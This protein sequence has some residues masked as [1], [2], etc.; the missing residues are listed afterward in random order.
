MRKRATTLVIVLAL[1]L[2]GS[3]AV[4]RGW[5][6]VRLEPTKTWVGV[7]RVHLE[8]SELTVVDNALVGTY[9]IRVPLAPAR[10]DRGTIRFEL[11]G[12]LEQTLV[13]GAVLSGLGQSVLDHRT[14]RIRCAFGEDDSV[15]ID[16]DS[17]DRRLSFRSRWT[18]GA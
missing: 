4:A 12:P 16:V 3:L 1:A 6:G 17:G 9:E 8:V 14:H 13:D 11:G 18:R 2:G 10:D 5:P 15:R 7:A